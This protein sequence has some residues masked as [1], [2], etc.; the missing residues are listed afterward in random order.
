M[1]QTLA[2]RVPESRE[3]L[4]RHSIVWHDFGDKHLNLTRF[5]HHLPP[6]HRRLHI[7]CERYLRVRFECIILRLDALSVILF[8]SWESGKPVWSGEVGGA[9]GRGVRG[10]LCRNFKQNTATGIL[11][12]SFINQ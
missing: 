4:W 3:I 2:T 7:S 5:R 9:E 12:Y 11:V 6:R 10:G 1:T 8:S